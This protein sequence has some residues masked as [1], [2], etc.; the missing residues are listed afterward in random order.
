MRKIFL[1]GGLFLALA[2]VVLLTQKNMQTGL[3]SLPEAGE[4]EDRDARTAYVIE[5]LKYE[6]D[7]I[8]DPRTG[9][10]PDGIFEKEM[11]FARTL[12]VRGSGGTSSNSRTQLLNTYLPAGPNNIGGRTRAVAYDVRYNGTSNRVIIAGCVSGGIMRSTDGG[13]TWRLVT[14]END[15][16]SFTALAQD[17]RPGFQDTWYAGGGEFLGNSAGIA[18]LTN[19]FGFGVWKSTD[20]GLTWSKLTLTITDINGSTLAPGTLENFDH[21]FDIVHRMA[22]NP[23]NG[24]LLVAGHRRLIRSTDAGASFNVVFGSTVPANS[25]N[26]QMDIAITN[27]GRVYLAVNGANPDPTLRGIWTSPTGNAN[28]FTRIAGGNTIGVDSIAGWRA[29]NP[30][31]TK[32]RRVLISLAPSNQNIG[33]VF[34]E[35]GLSASGNDPKPE[36]DLFRFDLS[37]STYTWSNRS[38]NMPD[39]P[40][41]NLDGVDPLTVQGG[42]DM[43]VRVFPTDPNI[44]YIGGTNLYRSFDGFATTSSIAWINGY[45]NLSSAAVYPNGHPDIHDLVFNPVNPAEALSANDGGLQVTPNINAGSGSFIFQPVSWTMIPN[46]QTLQYYYVAMDPDPFRNNF[47]G[48]AQDNGVQLRERIQLFAPQMPDTNDHRRI[49][50]ADGCA[51]G[52]SKI[53]TLNQN[54]FIYYSYQLGYMRR[55]EVQTGQSP[56]IHPNNLTKNPSYPTEPGGEFITNFRINQDNTEDAYYVN[57]NRLFRTTSASSVAGGGWVELTGVAA[58]VN[59]S[60]P[61]GGTDL[62]IRGMAFTRGIYNSSHSLYLGTTGGKIFRLDDPRNVAAGTAP[63]DITPPGL[64]GNVQD[65][66]VHPNNDNEVLA[67][68][69][70]YGVISIWWTN[71][72]KSSSPNWVN[73]EGNL[74]LPSIRSCMITVKKDATGNP[75]TEY[76]VGTSVG[77]YGT[78]AIGSNTV[79]QREGAAVL[80]YAVV[81]TMAYRP[82]DNVLLIGTHGNGMYFTYLGPSAFNPATSIN[83]VVNDKNFVKQVYP[84]LVSNAGIQYF[85]GNQAGIRNIQVQVFDA[86][87]KTVYSSQLPYQAG[88]LPTAQFA[89][90]AYTLVITSSDNRYRHVQKF[91]KQ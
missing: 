14:P 61:G 72:A 30:N 68:V 58:A 35:N 15:I 11:A 8:K 67:V 25:E 4:D 39:Y 1:F 17:P 20:N 41:G 21:P 23:A 48:G 85:T 49:F 78:T 88:R 16:H 77:L 24:H 89:A 63:V 82:T 45:R 55:L 50:S 32:G 7:M 47:V 51:V 65:I 83:Q 70:N 31:G 76:Y 33:Y 79:W 52:F 69:S 56:T 10:I 64:T 73:A 44:V 37:G 34:Y 54:Q 36:A 74:T 59:P 29:N 80:N 90:G 26:G 81:Q 28:S 27:A 38:A 22:V 75:V 5:R 2:A 18:A 84:T 3:A 9:K 43:M 12:P 19:Y 40:A 53:N 13:N 86:A 62:R 46:Y 42:Y 6:F 71:N 91:V 57:F 87:G 66:S 60:N